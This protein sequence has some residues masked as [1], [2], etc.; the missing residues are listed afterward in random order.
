MFETVFG[1]DSENEDSSRPMFTIRVLFFGWGTFFSVK[2]KVSASEKKSLRNDSNYLFSNIF[3]RYI[4]GET[5]NIL[6]PVAGQTA[7]QNLDPMNKKVLQN[8]RVKK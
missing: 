1:L 2:K 4:R 5:S 6:L 7:P 3:G 8:Q